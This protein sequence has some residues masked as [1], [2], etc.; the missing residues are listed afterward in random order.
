MALLSLLAC[1]HQADEFCLVYCKAHANVLL[2]CENAVLIQLISKAGKRHIVWMDPVACDNG[3]DSYIRAFYEYNGDGDDDLGEAV[4]KQV[5]TPD[6]DI[7]CYNTNAYFLNTAPNGNM[8]IRLMKMFPTQDAVESLDYN[9]EENPQIPINVFLAKLSLVQNN[10]LEYVT[11]C[12]GIVYEDGSRNY[13]TVFDEDYHWL[14]EYRIEAF[15]REEMP[16][17]SIFK[18]NGYYYKLVSD[19]KGKLCLEKSSSVFTFSRPKPV[20]EGNIQARLI[21][22]YRKSDGT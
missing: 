21:P 8:S 2:G 12:W 14:Q 15:V 6:K 10:A 16:V 13:V 19:D 17:G 3:I 4:S 22:L 9:S 20:V 18:K 11:V 7:F 5:I 1:S